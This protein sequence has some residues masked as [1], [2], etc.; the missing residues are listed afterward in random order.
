MASSKQERHLIFEPYT[1]VPDILEHVHV[2]NAS[3]QRMWLPNAFHHSDL[4]LDYLGLVW[5]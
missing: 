5:N 2:E 1:C 3:L 4:S